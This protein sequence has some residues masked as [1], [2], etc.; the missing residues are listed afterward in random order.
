[1]AATHHSYNVLKMPGS[2]GV[3]TVPF[4]DKDAVCSL[5]RAFQ[6]A[7]LEDLDR[8]SRRLP[9]TAP[10]KKKTSSGPAPQGTRLPR[11]NL[12]P[13]H[14]KARPAPSSGR[15]R[16]LSPGGSPTSPRSRGRRL[17]TTWRRVSKH[18]S[19]KEEQG[20]EGQTLRSLARPF[21]SYMSQE[22]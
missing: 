20:K 15:A 19:L 12:L 13:S 18:V 17:G 10:K 11:G 14:R 8:G 1:M 2:G 6:T 7:S 5:E 16:G 3:I 22:S 21:R 9:E 4:K